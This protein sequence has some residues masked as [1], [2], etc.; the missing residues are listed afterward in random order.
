MKEKLLPTLTL[1]VD[2]AVIAGTTNENVVEAIPFAMAVTVKGSDPNA[3]GKV[4]VTVSGVAPVAT[5]F[6]LQFDVVA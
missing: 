6:E 4:T 2:G 3:V 5:Q 1:A